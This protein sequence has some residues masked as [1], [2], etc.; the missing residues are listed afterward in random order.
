MKL[1]NKF[2]KP[3]VFISA[4]SFVIGCNKELP[5]AEPIVT[6][7]PTGST[8]VEALDDANFSILK[9]AVNRAGAPLKTILSDKNA[10]YTFFAPTDAAFQ[11]SG[12]PSV[13]VINMLRPGF[14]DTV[15]RY[16]LVGG[17]KLTTAS[18]PT[19]F[20][21]IQEPSMLVLAA[22][23]ASLPP[24]LRMPI[25]PS[26]RG[27]IVWANNIPVLQGDIEVAN[28][29][30]H[31]VAAIVAPPQ[32]FLWNKIDTAAD[33]TYL[34]AAILRADS[35]ATATGSLQAAL[36]NP[37]ASLT[38]FA[39]TNLAFQQILT[40]QITLALMA[41][42]M[43]QAT[44]GATASF[45]AS[46]PD[47]FSNPALFSALSAQ[48]VKGIVVYHLLG[49]RAFL[50]NFPTTPANVPTLLNTAI[51]AHPGVTLQATFDGS[52]FSVTNATVKGVANPSASNILVS[53]IPAPK[54]TSDQHYINGVI[55]V[56]DQ[57]LRPQ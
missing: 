26:K 16:H 29:V 55:H 27:N 14:L 32:Q 43:D 23:S 40:G 8:I 50:V 1:I 38:V 41:Q 10:V 3:F 6:P 9:A 42:G 21:N 56:I 17:Q 47:V 49:Q 12:I 46:T 7:A 51:A 13:D 39:P 19:T 28:G 4:A 18:I 2:F 31:K 33:L 54:G 48:T 57:V 30:I 25:F 15:L 36:L 22:P 35:G 37:A 45:L 53:P 24:G 20:P 44:A 5:V 52:G 34:R 11:A